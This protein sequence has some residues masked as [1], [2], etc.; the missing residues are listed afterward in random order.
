MQVKKVSNVGC[1]VF[2]LLNWIELNWIE[3]N[4]MFMFKEELILKAQKGQESKNYSNIK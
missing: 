2:S 4:W 1:I 3:L